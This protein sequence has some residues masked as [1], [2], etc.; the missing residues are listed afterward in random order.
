MKIT[1]SHKSYFLASAVC[2]LFCSCAQLSLF[3]DASTDGKGGF[4]AG[5]NAS[6]MKYPQFHKFEYCGVD[7]V[8]PAPNPQIGVTRRIANVFGSYGVTE[9]MDLQLSA[10]TG[11]NVMFSP[12]VQ[13]LNI[14]NSK[15]AFAVNPAIEYQIE[16][17]DLSY[18]RLHYACIGSLKIVDQLTYFVEPRFISERRDMPFNIK[19]F[20]TGLIYSLRNGINISL[21]CS[22]FSVG[23][24]AKNIHP[25]SQLAIGV[26]YRMQK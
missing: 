1:F 4:S 13:L 16:Q 14:D 20:S 3:Q 8:V 5:L 17:D 21:G 9:F 23:R 6:I 15:L 22:S 10:S 26:K 24:K 11:M 19:G 25:A 12:K 7:C 2:L 18:I